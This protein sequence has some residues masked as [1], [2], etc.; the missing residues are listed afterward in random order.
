MLF[1]SYDGL[2]V[3]P[4]LPSHWDGFQATRR[5]RGASY[6]IVVPCATDASRKTV[7][8]SVDGRPIE[9]TLVPLAPAGATVN[10]EVRLS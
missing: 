7:Q 5:F 4:C 9:G 2:R 8:V 10:V 6:S 1:R 3:E